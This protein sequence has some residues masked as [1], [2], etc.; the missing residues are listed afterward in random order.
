MAKRKRTKA[1][2]VIYKTLQRKL[3]IVLQ[4]PNKKPEVNPHAPEG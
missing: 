2:I 3:K 4:E 1:Q